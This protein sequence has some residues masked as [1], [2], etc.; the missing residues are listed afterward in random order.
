MLVP[1]P[2]LWL[3]IVPALIRRLSIDAGE[4]DV[5]LLQKLR[6]GGMPAY[7][8]AAIAAAI[9]ATVVFEVV[10]AKVKP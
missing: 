7:M 5:D 4:R 2:V 6:A 8:A 3:A 10:V 9:E 1:A